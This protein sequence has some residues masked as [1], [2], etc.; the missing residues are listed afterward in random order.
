MTAMSTAARFRALDRY[1]DSTRTGDSAIE[2]A[3]ARGL[4]ISKIMR[5]LGQDY[6][7]VK[8]IR[9]RMDHR[10][11]GRRGRPRAA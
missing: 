9:D 6:E 2:Q 10:A 8:A 3:I 7:T 4:P 11:N 1:I 5:T